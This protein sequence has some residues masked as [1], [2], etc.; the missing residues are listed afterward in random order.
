M[1]QYVVFTLGSEKYGLN[2][3]EVREIIR[4]TATTMMPQTPEYIDGIINLR[5]Q[6]VPVVKLTSRFQIAGRETGD[7]KIV[8]VEIG[9]HHVGLIVDEVTEVLAVEDQQVD[10]APE[11]VGN[12]FINGIAKVKEE[13]VILLDIQNLFSDREIKSLK[14]E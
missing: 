11:T 8:I 13:L 10:K 9:A 14:I 3:S 6:I 7:R 2:I 5:G 12:P 4:Y 1:K